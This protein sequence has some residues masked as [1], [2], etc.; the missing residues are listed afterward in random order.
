ML[1]HGH[2]VCA[3][4]SLLPLSGK[5]TS[6]KLIHVEIYTYIHCHF[7]TSSF[8]YFSDLYNEVSLTSVRGTILG[9]LS[10]T[11]KQGQI[12]E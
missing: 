6:K 4:L 2:F 8:A 11:G 3:D 7:Y 5:K 12:S 10:F 1:L 9:F